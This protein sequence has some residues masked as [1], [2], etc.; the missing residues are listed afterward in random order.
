[1][2]NGRSRQRNT[3]HANRQRNIER[4]QVVEATMINPIVIP[5]AD[6]IV[7]AEE[8]VADAEEVANL[9]DTI[10]SISQDITEK[11]LYIKSIEKEL[12]KT[13]K[14]YDD[15]KNSFKILLDDFEK[16]G[17]ITKDL[18]NDDNWKIDNV[19]FPLIMMTGDYE[20][21]AETTSAKCVRRYVKFLEMVITA[22][23]NGVGIMKICGGFEGFEMNQEK[24]AELFLGILEKKEKKGTEDL[25]GKFTQNRAQAMKDVCEM[26][27]KLNKPS[28]K[29]KSKKVKKIMVVNGKTG[30]STE[31]S[32]EEFIENGLMNVI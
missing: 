31:I 1:M 4:S 5:D 11:K 32:Q 12:K 15:N 17:F 18:S 30:E 2:P 19:P 10:V 6:I 13:Q 22:S 25:L 16:K 7:E 14:S 8:L 26:K 20:N 27:E 21:Q 29:K 24:C 23:T 3:S 9:K 28:K